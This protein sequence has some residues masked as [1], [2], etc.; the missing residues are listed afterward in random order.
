M[1]WLGGNMNPILTDSENLRPSTQL[2]PWFVGALGSRLS[3]GSLCLV[4]KESLVRWR[5]RKGP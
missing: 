5:W 2:F 4:G 3:L 1:I